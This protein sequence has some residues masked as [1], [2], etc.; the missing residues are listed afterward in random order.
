MATGWVAVVYTAMFMQGGHPPLSAYV[1]AAVIFASWILGTVGLLAG[2][3]SLKGQ[4]A[5]RKRAAP[6]TFLNAGFLAFSVFVY[7]M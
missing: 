2:V 1:G 7:F 3:A 5:Q 4:E 6:F